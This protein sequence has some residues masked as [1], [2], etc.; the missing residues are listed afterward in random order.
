MLSWP[1]NSPNLNPAE[2]LWDV[3]DWR[4]LSM[5]TPPHNLQ[6]LNDLLLMSWFQI[7]QDKFRGL[8]TSELI[9][10]H[11]GDLYDTRQVIFN[12]MADQCLYHSIQQPFCVILHNLISQLSFG[13]FRPRGIDFS[14]CIYMSERMCLC[15]QAGSTNLTIPPSFDRQSFKTGEPVLHNPSL[16]KFKLQVPTRLLLWHK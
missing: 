5:E 14:L 10:L 6:D 9:C 8:D 2:H 1:P 7:P 11:D 12:V 13:S 3:L 16:T 15:M 4:I